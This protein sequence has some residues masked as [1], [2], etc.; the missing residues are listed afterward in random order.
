MS[1]SS[2]EEATRAYGSLNNKEVTDY[3]INRHFHLEYSPVELKGNSFDGE[4][5]SPVRMGIVNA[6]EQ[7]IP[8][9]YIF[10]EF[11]SSKEEEQMIEGIEKG[12]WE[13]L[14]HRKVQHFGFQFDYSFNGVQKDSPIS[15]YNHSS[16]RDYLNTFPE[17]CRDV[18]QRIVSHMQSSFGRSDDSLVFIPDQLTV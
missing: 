3:G 5:Q 15:N 14:K 7:K 10:K 18:L 16:P 12:K 13:N 17:Y 8:G 4:L 9:L 1:F 2:I 11:I 6:T